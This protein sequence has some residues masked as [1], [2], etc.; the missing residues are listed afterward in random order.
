[1]NTTGDLRRMAAFWESVVLSAG[2][3]LWYVHSNPGP[4]S[5][6]ATGEMR[7]VMHGGKSLLKN[8]ER[9]AASWFPSVHPLL[10]ELG[11]DG[12]VCC[13]EVGLHR[14]GC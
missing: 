3:R 7:Q 13:Y 6:V 1:M 12:D 5:Q 2:F 11:A 14:Q 8:R 10:R 9:R 4:A